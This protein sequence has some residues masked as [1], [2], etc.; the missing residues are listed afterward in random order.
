M[1]TVSKSLAF[2]IFA[3]LLMFMMSCS[4]AKSP[5][6][7]APS[8]DNPAPL[9]QSSNTDPN[10]HYLWGY[11]IVRINPTDLSSE[12]IPIRLAASHMNV[13]QFLEQAPCAN[14][15]KLAGIIKNPDGTLSV[16]ISIKHPYANLNFTG[17]DVRGIA[18]FNGTHQFPA[19]GLVTSDRTLGEGE[20]INPDGFT[21]LYNPTTIGHGLEGYKK[22]KLA[23][24]ATPSSTLNAFKRFI[25]N[26]PANT[27][28]AFYAGGTI[29]VTYN[30]DMPDTPNPWVFGYAVDSSWAAP[31]YKPV[32]NPMTDFA[33]SSN[34]P[35]SYK[36]VVQDMGPG[37]QPSGGSTELQIDVYDWQWKDIS[38]PAVIECPD[39]FD[40]EV[41]ATWKEDGIGF[42]R[43]SAI[44][45][46]T[47]QAGMGNY[48]C[49]IGKEASEN[50]PSGKPW[51]DLTAYQI[52]P[53]VV[54]AVPLNPVDVTPPWLV[55]TPL[56]VCI[57]GD[58][59][60]TVSERHGLHIFN[61]SDTANPVWVNWVDTPGS[62]QGVAV[63]GAYAYVADT[64]SG[65]Q[66]IDIDPP[67]SA[68]IV[69]TVDTPYS[70]VGVAVSGGYAYIADDESGLQIIDVDPPESAHIVLALDIPYTRQVVVSGNYANAIDLFY[71]D[72]PHSRLYV[73]DIQQPESAYVVNT[74]D[75]PSQARKV[76]ASDGY[77]YVNVNDNGL[78]IVD[79]DPPESAYIVNSVATP[80]FNDGLA[81]SN[82]YAYVAVGKT[83]LEI[84]DIDPP[85]SASVVKSV[86]THEA[87]RVAVSGGYACVVDEEAGLYVIDID[88][89]D[90]SQ[91]VGFFETCF[92]PDEVQTSG[93]Y[94]YVASNDLHIVDITQPESARIVKAVELAGSGAVAVY[95]GYAYTLDY[96]G[97]EV[98]D[99]DP[100]ESAH[101][102]SMLDAEAVPKWD[103]TV[104]DGYAAFTYCEW[105]EGAL[106][107]VDTD[108]IED[109]D[110]AKFINDIGI[111]EGGVTTSNGYA[112]VA[113]TWQL[114]V[115]D[116][117][118]VNDAHAVGNVGLD[119]PMEVTVSGSY[120]YVADWQSGLKI[121]DIA[122][123]K[124]PSIVKTVDTPGTARGVTISGG[125][126]YVADGNSLQI[127]DIDPPESAHIISSIAIYSGEGV[128]GVA[129]SGNYAYVTASTN[130][131]RI[132]KLW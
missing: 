29:V 73:I 5:D 7:I 19:S 46:N 113:N 93:N 110:T 28:N 52:F 72:P 116:I 60:Y 104:W 54:S 38:H 57:Q 126:A 87:F 127:V 58:Y 130:G 118:P 106:I 30:I 16:N 128:T 18:M 66:I 102:V 65:L 88:P 117:D 81:V 9:T 94:V 80:N 1:K 61:I 21:T 63:Q 129:V 17:F 96:Y 37:L 51:L 82:G 10:T 76:A 114:V 24:P 105:L 97:L 50:D 4:G 95:Q 119:Q 12:I 89:L 100:W 101:I 35:E 125:Y 109:I 39:L 59:A 44:I 56:D 6:P 47:K 55:F 79:V 36:L 23:T 132:I 26:I 77:A 25:T 13:L 112:Y 64:W 27:R 103:I 42:T 14:C 91:I 45:Q 124:S 62:P 68:Y 11:Y 84:I 115:V 43:Y 123:P 111:P 108:P 131:L 67:E 121:I 32:I 83:G 70:A 3:G 48:S 69:T 41:Q 2:I 22:G 15:F 8:S 31:I 33:L 85:E 71:G 49:L 53:V 86:T 99:I 98:I 34:C 90:S 78:Q 120:V 75:M 92:Q 40:G 20:I 122:S 107:I 74:I